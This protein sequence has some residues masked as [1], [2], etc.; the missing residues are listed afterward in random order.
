MELAN[1]TKVI[2]RNWQIKKRD[3]NNQP[4]NNKAST[5]F[6]KLYLFRLA[7]HWYVRPSQNAICEDIIGTIWIGTIDRL[8]ALHPWGGN[9]GHHTTKYSNSQALRF[10]MNTF[11]G[12]TWKRKRIQYRFG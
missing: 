9:P 11:P 3:P 12:S 10:L 2:C 8:T 7:F 4:N 6:Q 5:L 1:L